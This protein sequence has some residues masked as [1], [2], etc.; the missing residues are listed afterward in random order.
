MLII[1]MFGEWEL[2]TVTAGVIGCIGIANLTKPFLDLNA[3]H[4][5]RKVKMDSMD[6]DRASE[7]CLRLALL[8]NF[9]TVG[10]P[11]AR[12]LITT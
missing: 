1:S 5:G 12:W 11:R 4:Q 8:S 6:A 10:S 2:V 9:A 3:N 7:V